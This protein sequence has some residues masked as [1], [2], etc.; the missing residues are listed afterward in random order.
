MLI[1]DSSE[2][3][4]ASNFNDVKQFARALSLLWHVD[5]TNGVLFA[6]VAFSDNVFLSADFKQYTTNDQVDTAI[7]QIPYT[8]GATNTAK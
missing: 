3:I 2:S 1:F 6:F 7:S 5:A 8:P 4:T